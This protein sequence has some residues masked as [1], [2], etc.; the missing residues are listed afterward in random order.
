VSPRV[1]EGSL[2]PRLYS[3]ACARPLNFTVRPHD[4]TFRVRAVMYAWISVGLA[5][6]AWAVWGLATQ[7][8]YASVVESWLITLAFAVLALAAGL[9][10]GGGA[11][12]GPVLVRVVSSLAILYS[13]AWLLLGGVDDAFGYW[14]AIVAAVALSVYSLGVSRR[15]RAA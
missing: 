7:D 8:H 12:I 9:T 3:D 10:F 6:A 14:P 5:L 11:A 2:H 13:G 1:R 15:A 4:M